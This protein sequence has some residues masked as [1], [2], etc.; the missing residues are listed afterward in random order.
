MLEY[1]VQRLK[2]LGQKSERTIN[3]IEKD[4][5]RFLSF[6]A[7]EFS[8]EI[9]AASVMAYIEELEQNYSETSFA[10]KLSNLRQ[11]INWLD[12]EENPFWHYSARISA[13]SFKFYSHDEIFVKP[14]AEI[15]DANP[16]SR[17]INKLVLSCIY[18]F[19]LSTRELI[20]LKLGDY[21]VASG[22]LSLRGTSLEA[23]HE[24]ALGLKQYLATTRKNYVLGDLGIDDHLLVNE[25]SLPFSQTDLRKRLKE[26]GLQPLYVKRSY[27]MH[28]LEQGKSIREIEEKLALRLSNAY[29]G[30]QQ[31]PDYRLL[32]AYNQFHPR[33]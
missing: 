25:K 12:I 32:K 26:L 8:G 15:E 9:N 20:A 5:L 16:V 10:A 18:E 28:L 17:E 19:H 23:C 1:F 22:E 29:E 31:R 3:A 27:I 2:D 24:L 7:K 11:F 30:F 4:L 33:A 14:F 21:N 6:V 13:D